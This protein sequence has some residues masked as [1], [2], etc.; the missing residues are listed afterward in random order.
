MSVFGDYAQFYDALYQEKDYEA[1]CDFVEQIFTRYALSP[2]T[3]ILDLGCGTG[4][5]ALPLARRGYQVTGVDLSEGMLAQARWKSTSTAGL[6]ISPTFEQADIRNLDL[7]HDLDA[8]ISMFAVMSYMTTN[9]ELL[10][11]FRTARRHLRRGGL[12]IFDAWFG[13]AVLR[14]RP[15]DRYKIVKQDGNDIIRFV[16]SDL[17][18]LAHTVQVQYKVLCLRQNQVVKDVTETHLMRFLFSQEIIGFL[19]STN[20]KLCKFSPFLQLDDAIDDRSWN[21]AVIAEAV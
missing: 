9:N 10:S 18:L 7:G 13:P 14:D 8:V 5:H 3:S 1:E 17:D 16:H 15:A 12:F 21:M 4:G 11:V 6:S 2:I 20:F 19:E